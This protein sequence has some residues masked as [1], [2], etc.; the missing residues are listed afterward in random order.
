M[1]RDSP[2]EVVKVK[3]HLKEDGPEVTASDEAAVDF[4][5]NDFADQAARVGLTY[6]SDSAS[7]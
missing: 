2:V 6:D 3:A 4:A 5:G 7:Y 1:I